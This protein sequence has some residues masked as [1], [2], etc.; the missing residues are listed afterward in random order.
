MAFF[1]G[2][3]PSAA[4]VCQKPPKPL[5]PPGFGCSHLQNRLDFEGL[6]GGAPSR[7]TAFRVGFAL[8]G[9]LAA[10]SSGRTGSETAARAFHDGNS[11]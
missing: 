10:P 11:P 1:P 2:R 9:P 8:C 5:G 7:R 3:G 6:R 4:V